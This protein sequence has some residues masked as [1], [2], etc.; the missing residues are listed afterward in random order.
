M[1]V[2]VTV[3]QPDV[4]VTATPTS[5]GAAP[6]TLSAGTIAGI[7]VGTLLAVV[8]IVVILYLLNRYSRRKFIRVANPAH[9]GVS[10]ARGAPDLRHLPSTS[11]WRP[12]LLIRHAQK[13]SISTEPLMSP[14]S[15]PPPPSTS[16]VQSP[17][18]PRS[19]NSISPGIRDSQYSSYDL[20]EISQVIACETVS[21]SAS[22]AILN[23]PP[24][25]KPEQTSLRSGLDDTPPH[26]PSPPTSPKPFL[27]R[28][29][30]SRAQA[31]EGVSLA[32]HPSLDAL[33][34]RSTT[35]DSST[36]HVDEERLLA[37]AE[38][39]A[40]RDAENA[41]RDEGG[42]VPDEED[43]WAEGDTE[44]IYSQLSA[45][46]DHSAFFSD[47]LSRQ[48]SS[49]SL[50]RRKSSRRQPRTA[51]PPTELPSVAEVP[52]TP[53]AFESRSLSRRTS[54]AGNS[55]LDGQ[56]SHGTASR[57]MSSVIDRPGTL[58]LL[59]SA[60][61]GKNS[62][63]SGTPP[64]SVSSNKG[65]GSGSS[66]RASRYP[67]L[68]PSSIGQSSRSGPRSDAGTDWY[69]P[70]SGLAG[71]SS[72]QIGS[73]RNPHSPVEEL[74]EQPDEP[75]TPSFADPVAAKRARLREGTVSWV[76]EVERRTVMQGGI[77]HIDVAL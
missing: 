18:A 75:L 53:R 28:M 55:S 47:P 61:F 74:P 73:L 35:L 31:S 43:D 14:V 32:Y 76:P 46:I 60:D 48:N 54:A 20:G 17:G 50:P 11:S 77:A 63:A 34:S 27:R 59:T 71:L 45:P 52:D 39:T 2:V 10:A 70:P 62:T 6:S 67:S 4:T 65:W 24:V 33:T 23:I 5:S 19:E 40:L 72:L 16:R 58:P 56:V 8:F 38:Y 69:H 7:V 37:E 57:P 49:S 64:G 30:Q 41:Q 51:A 36:F 13:P 26:A 68:A 12:Q 25:R 1:A 9:D 21:H 3:T 15:H 29:L 44:S 42:I 22:P 66:G